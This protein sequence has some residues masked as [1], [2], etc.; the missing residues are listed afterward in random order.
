MVKISAIKIRKGI[1]RFEARKR[2]QYINRYKVIEKKPLEKLKDSLRKMFAPKKEEKKQAASTVVSEGGFNT[3]LVVGAI[4]LALLILFSGFLWW[5]INQAQPTPAPFQQIVKGSVFNS[6]LGWDT[7]TAGSRGTTNHVATITFDS[8]VSGLNNYTINVK[9]YPDDL[10]SEFFILNSDRVEAVNYQEFLRHLRSNLSQK[11]IVLNEI[12]LDQLETVPKG[13]AVIVP[14]GAI[15]YEMLE[16]PANISRLLDEGV[17]VI[18][19]GQSFKSM[20][21]DTFITT[22]P[23]SLTNALPVSFNE[24]SVPTCTNDLSLFQPLYRISGTGGYSASIIYGCVS[25]LKKGSGAILFVPQTLKGGWKSEPKPAASDI[26]KIVFET[27]WSNPDDADGA[28]YFVDL[29]NTTNYTGGVQMLH[30]LPFQGTD[31]TVKIEFTGFS[32]TGVIV[33]D[34]KFTKVEKKTNGELYVSKL[35]VTSTNVTGEKIRMNGLLS[36]SAASTPLMYLVFTNSSGEVV[37][38][39]LQGNINTQSQNVNFDVPIYLDEGEY[40]VT[41][42]DDT[43]RLYASSY[44]KVSSVLITGPRTGAKPSVYIFEVST[45]ITLKTVTVKVDNQA[46]LTFEDVSNGPLSLD[47][48][49][50]TGGDALS[51]GNHTFEFTAGGL[52]KTISYNRPLPPPPF[53][54]ELLLVALLAFGIVGVGIY[55]ARQ[56]KTFFSL[57]VP[58]FPPV[59]RTKIPLTSEAVLSI[60]D[61]VNDNYKWEFTPLTVNE[62]KNGFKDVFYRGNPIYITD[63]NTE[64]L[65]QDLERSKHIGSFLD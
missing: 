57:D 45:P 3:A 54:P 5:S 63:Y 10:P 20:I 13:A 4:A 53:P 62:V 52:Q 44:L 49:P 11:G 26:A 27:K 59:S 60:F 16:G 21:K 36:E 9:T 58:D 37:G 17:V 61:K 8:K 56:E 46:P 51:Y 48:T 22:T 34:T 1:Y 12:T 14:S 50:F 33:E 43:G 24:V 18:Y 23:T 47:V 40:T 7:L 55:F 30:S 25:V 42:E 41:L 29:A 15:P 31:R 39:E 65:L 2:Y 19:I 6:V 28:S 38:Q 35:T 32:T 64:F